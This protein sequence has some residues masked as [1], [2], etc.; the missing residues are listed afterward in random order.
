V[1]L[2]EKVNR[3]GF[4]VLYGL[5]P[6]YWYLPITATWFAHVMKG[7]GHLLLPTLP[8]QVLGLLVAFRKIRSSPYRALSL[9]LVARHQC[10]V[11]RVGVLRV[12]NSSS[13]RRY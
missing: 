2:P 5:S 8:L 10:L 6:G 3:L 4:G 1:P 7:Y 13:R 11:G 12:L 9:A